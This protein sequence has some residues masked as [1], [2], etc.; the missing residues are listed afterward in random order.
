MTLK[1]INSILR[2]I[3]LA[4]CVIAVGDEVFGQTYSPLFPPNSNQSGVAYCRYS[5]GSR[6]PYCFM[7]L[8]TV[9][10]LYTNGHFHDSVSHPWSTVTP[11][12]GTS[13]GAGNLYITLHTT[14]V[15]QAELLGVEDVFHDLFG[16]YGYAVGYGDIYWNDHPELWD[17]VGGTDTGADTGHGSTAYNHWMEINAAWGIYY[18]STDYL[19]AHPEQGRLCM[20]DM[21]LPFAGK[22][23]ITQNW[24]SPHGEHDRGKAVDVGDASSGQCAVY[25]SGIPLAN[26]VEFRQMCINRGAISGLSYLETAH[27]HCGWG[28]Q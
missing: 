7:R 12:E 8:F 21:A 3:I 24:N 2:T 27:V 26:R 14:R 15:G 11:T 22:F 16:F 23:D 18:T 19:S 4:A 13:D 28:L 5:D 20:N 9:V 25:G 6:I 1:K 17:R 10:Y